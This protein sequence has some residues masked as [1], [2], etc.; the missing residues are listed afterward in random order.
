LSFMSRI[1]DGLGLTIP[2]IEDGCGTP[3]R[4]F[5]EKRTINACN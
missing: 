2:S 5:K 1:K 4:Q 3:R